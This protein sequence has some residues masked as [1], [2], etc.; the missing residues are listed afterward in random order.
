MAS[1][2][3]VLSVSNLNEYVSRLLEND[4]RL[5]S[6][7]VSGELSGF[8]RHS[9]GHLYFSLKDENALIRCVM[10][11]S[12]AM[13]L[14]FEP[15]DGMQVVLSGSVSLYVKDGQYQFYATGMRP[16]GE[17]ELYKRFIELRDK[18]GREG[19]FD[20]SRPI[21]FLPRCVGVVT[22]ETGAAFHDIRTVIARRF[23]RMRILLAPAQ[24]Q[25]AGAAYSIVEGIRILNDVDEVDVIIVGRGGGS[26]EDLSCFNDEALARAIFAS[27]KP[28]VSAVGHEVDF[29]IADF[30]SDLRAPT[31]SAAAELCVPELETLKNSIRERFERMFALVDSRISAAKQQLKLLS[32]DSVLK[33]PSVMLEIKRERLDSTAKLLEQRIGEAITGAYMR[34]ETLDRRL[35]ALNPFAVLKRGYAIVL[36][37]NGETVCRSAD[38]TAGERLKIRFDDGTLDATVD[39]LINAGTRSPN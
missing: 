16:S 13:K 19:L 8:K 35:E 33:K 4:L 14:N 30:V 25:G 22:S 18:L 3:M 1:S 31:P 28:V 34:L 39:A 29:T 20:R 32:S 37:E 11:R 21:P 23:P 10:F 9:S 7:R 38:A 5:R 2:E 26:Y 15:S 27:G 17:G 6:L 12:S 36:N 24:V